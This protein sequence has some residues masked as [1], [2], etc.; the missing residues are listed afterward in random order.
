MTVVLIGVGA[1]SDHVQPKL[2]LTEDGAFDYI[3]IPES[4]PSGE[5]M[6]YGDWPLKHRR[7][8]AA[9]FVEG[10]AHGVRTASGSEMRKLSG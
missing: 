2:E 10:L 9:D 7:G 1:D 4:Y 5:S 8:T 6:T 3:P